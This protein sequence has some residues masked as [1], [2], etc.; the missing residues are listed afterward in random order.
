MSRPPALMVRT[1]DALNQA[2]AALASAP[3]ATLDT[4]FMRE[5]TYFPQLCLVQIATPEALWL[6]DP[7][8]V[9]LAPLWAILNA[10]TAPLILHAAEQD[11]ELIYLAAHALPPI[12]RDSQIAAAFLG[13]GDQMGYGNLV[14]HLLGITLDKS[15]SRTNWADRPLSEAQRHYAADDVHYLA[16]IYPELCQRLADCG[17]LAWFEEDCAVLSN[18][19]RFEPQTSGLW[20][21]VRGQQLL[22]SSQRRVLQAIALWR[23]QWARQLDL[24]R[25]WVLSDEQ[26][27]E[28]ANSRGFRA[29]ILNS[30]HNAR[31]KLNPNQI[32]DLRA[33]VDRARQLPIDDSPE[34]RSPSRLNPDTAALIA[35]M[36]TKVHAISRELEI[37]APLL[38]TADDLQKLIAA[39]DAPTCKLNQGWR[40]QV[41]A[42][43][44][45]ALLP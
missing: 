21:R 23:E 15:Q 9:D 1:A 43:P 31:H 16:L 10:R 29:E 19:Q 6:F 17:R 11:L 35:L 42:A 5:S 36:Q 3:T 45:K 37:S 40:S 30:H 28:L 44:L 18:T 34:W 38:A 14:Q 4:E 8:A 7:L 39:P 25:R 32:Q 41:I 13:L 20:R 33:A 27:L 26:A 22:R 2:C 12:L 24:P